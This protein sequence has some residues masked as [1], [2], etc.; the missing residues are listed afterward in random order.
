M[1]KLI[2]ILYMGLACCIVLSCNKLLSE[3]V[4]Q[5]TLSDE[6]VKDPAN[7]EGM[8]VAFRRALR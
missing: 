4:P 3:Q 2:S 1:R 8:V 5:A 7:A 6:Q